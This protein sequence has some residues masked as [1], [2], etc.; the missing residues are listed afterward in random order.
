MAWPII[1]SSTSAISSAQSCKGFAFGDRRCKLPKFLDGE[2]DPVAHVVA[3]VRFEV[4]LVMKGSDLLH[5]DFPFVFVAHGPSTA[6]RSFL[7]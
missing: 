5:H 4:V 1:S 2:C 3:V 7:A 6:L